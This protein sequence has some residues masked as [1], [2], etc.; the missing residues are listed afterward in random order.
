MRSATAT[1]RLWLAVA[2]AALAAAGL[3]AWGFT[4]YL[5]TQHEFAGA[6]ATDI[7]Y[8]TAQLFV[9]DPAPFSGSGP[10]PVGLEIARFL[11]PLTTILVLVETV[12]VLVRERVRR[13]AAAHRKG[14]VIVTGNEPFALMLAKR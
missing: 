7:A 8:Y 10:Y 6:R 11:A 1:F 13:W 4:D 9:L 3:G 12:R 14:Q 2:L 5:P